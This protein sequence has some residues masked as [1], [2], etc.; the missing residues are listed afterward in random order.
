MESRRIKKDDRPKNEDEDEVCTVDAKRNGTLPRR[1]P[2]NWPSW[3][4]QRKIN[5]LRCHLF[6]IGS[7]R[8][9]T[10]ELVDTRLIETSEWGSPFGPCLTREEG[11]EWI[12]PGLAYAVIE[13]QD[14]EVVI[15]EFRR[16]PVFNREGGE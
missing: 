8:P 2:L 12:K 10:H 7:Y 14:S 15:G 11:V 3:E 16:V 5:F 9:P 6:H 4:D 1:V 13:G